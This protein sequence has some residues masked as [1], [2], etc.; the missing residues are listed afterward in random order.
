M[1]KIVWA[2]S[3]SVGVAALDKQHNRIIE[4]INSLIVGP[5]AEVDS[6]T[7]SDTLG[8][9]LE[10]AR[11]HF[12]TEERILEEHDYPELPAQRRQHLAFRKKAATFCVE[13]MEGRAS[14]PHEVLEY[15]KSWFSEHVLETDMRYRTFL[16][17]R[18]VT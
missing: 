16:N 13:T 8:E 14:L 4:M 12:E 9:M 2:P 6:E 3:L 11:A 10:Y 17:E 7:L 15:L 1:E 5:D 18:G